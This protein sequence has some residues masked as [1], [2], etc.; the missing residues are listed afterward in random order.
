MCSMTLSVHYVRRGYGFKIFL[1]TFSRYIIS[2]PLSLYLIIMGR[3]LRHQAIQQLGEWF[4][5]K[6][7]INDKQELIQSGWYAK[8]RHPSYTGMLMIFAG[9][10]LL[11]NNWLGLVGIVIPPTFVFLYRLYI[12]EKELRAHFGSAYAEYAK[13]VPAKLIPHVF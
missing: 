13:K 7:R 1:N 6:I 4:T 12:E 2:L 8:M 5:L 11:I 3:I 9:L 10:G